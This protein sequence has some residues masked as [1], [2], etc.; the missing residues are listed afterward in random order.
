MSVNAVLIEFVKLGLERGIPKSQLDEALR[1]AGWDREQVG[2]ALRQFADVEF[3][4][5]VPRP[6]P[7]VTAREFFLYGVMFLALYL[8]AF[9]LGSVLFELV[10]RAFPM[11]PE[12]IPAAIRASQLNWSLAFLIVTSPVFAWMTWLTTAEL[13]IDPTKRASRV[14]RQLTYL[15]LF[16]A[17]AVLVGDVTTLVYSLLSGELTVRFLLKFLI[18]VLIAS[19]CFGYYLR[20]LHR[21]EE[22]LAA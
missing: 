15:T 19:A 22:A 16:I 12:R 3:A 7:Y 2:G 8:S 13:H 21:D 14:R 5:P 10:D 11:V 1:Q 20:Q 4:I 18:V 17:S 6:M 9:N